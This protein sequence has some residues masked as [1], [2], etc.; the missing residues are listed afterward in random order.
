MFRHV[1]TCFDLFRPVCLVPK[2]SGVAMLPWYALH[3]LLLQAKNAQMGWLQLHPSF[4]PGCK[5]SWWFHPTGANILPVSKNGKNKFNPPTGSLVDIL[6]TTPLFLWL[7]D[8]TPLS[9]LLNSYKPG[10]FRI[11]L[12]F[13]P[14]FESGPHS[15]S[16]GIFC[17]SGQ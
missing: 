8:E 9:P 2:Q 17:C 14:K 4:S 3:R 1:S 7:N 16:T 11:S 12:R 13:W 6:D 10:R 15:A 5:T